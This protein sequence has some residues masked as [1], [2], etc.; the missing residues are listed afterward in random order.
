MQ[1]YRFLLIIGII[2]ILIGGITFLTNIGSFVLGIN[3]KSPGVMLFVL[4]AAST[5][6]LIGV[7][8]LKFKRTAYNVLLY[9]S[10][11]VLLSKL[12]IFMGV[13]QLNGALETTI[14]ALWKR[15]VS[16]GYHAFL[17]YYLMKPGVRGI[18]HK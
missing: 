9:F 18:F 4:L 15:L 16:A 10:S 13:L 17:L 1:D 3:P 5:S 14:P 12:L 2:E 8:I 6:T 11:V 7:G